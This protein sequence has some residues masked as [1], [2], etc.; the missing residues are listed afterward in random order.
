MIRFRGRS[1]GRSPHVSEAKPAGGGATKPFGAFAIPLGL[2]TLAQP[3]FWAQ[4]EAPLG[5]GQ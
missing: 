1:R 3:R 5:R 2:D 4:R